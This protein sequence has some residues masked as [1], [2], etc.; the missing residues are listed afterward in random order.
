MNTTISEKIKPAYEHSKVGTFLFN[1]SAR[2]TEFLVK[3]RWLYYLL[4]CTWGIL[5]TALG[6]IATVILNIVKVVAEWIKPGKVKIDFKKYH[7]IYSISIGPKLWGGC[8][9]GLMF[10]R[11]HDSAGDLNEHEFG[12]TFQNCIFGPLFPFIVAIPSAA[13]WWMRVLKPNK[14]YKPYDSAWFEDA[15]TQCGMYAHKYLSNK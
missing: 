15:A 14:V 5:M 11:D 12:H 1:L 3:H 7:W 10:F 9:M 2:S 6:F 13:R 4:A 8:E